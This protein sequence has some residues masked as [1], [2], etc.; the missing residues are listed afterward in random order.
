MPSAVKD[1]YLQLLAEFQRLDDS[2]DVVDWT[3]LRDDILA[4][5]LKAQALLVAQQQ[6][7]R[8]A[9]GAP[10]HVM[11]LRAELEEIRSFMHGLQE[12]FGRVRE[13]ADS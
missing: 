1:L 4:A 2:D 11:L 10:G 5:M 6:T 3:A 9:V 13:R 8:E 12:L 7:V